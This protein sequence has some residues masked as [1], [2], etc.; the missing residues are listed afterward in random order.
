MRI[1]K[2][3]FFFCEGLT[4]LQTHD[5]TVPPRLLSPPCLMFLSAQI[6]Q[7]LISVVAEQRVQGVRHLLLSWG[8]EPS[9]G[10]AVRIWQ[11]S[12]RGHQ[13]RSWRGGGQIV[14]F[15]CPVCLVESKVKLPLPWL[16]LVQPIFIPVF[17]HYYTVLYSLKQ[18]SICQAKF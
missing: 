12:A 6:V 16:Q 14:G 13:G 3:L 17:V 2:F 5:N 18:T 9:G 8:T 7:G 10:E 15:S 1:L 4:I 11:Q